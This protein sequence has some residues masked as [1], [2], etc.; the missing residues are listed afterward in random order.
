MVLRAR[1]VVLSRIK[2][3]ASTL[4]TMHSTY[5]LFM[6]PSSDEFF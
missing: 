4:K 3:G 5:L 1:K 6:T 2:K